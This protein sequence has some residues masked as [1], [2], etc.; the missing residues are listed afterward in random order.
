MALKSPN[1]EL[2]CKGLESRARPSVPRS[3]PL[4]VPGAEDEDDEN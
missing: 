2:K 1:L 4:L 3:L